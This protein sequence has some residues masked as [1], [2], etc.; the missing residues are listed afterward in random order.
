MQAGLAVMSTAT[1]AWEPIRQVCV[2]TDRVKEAKVERLRRVF[3][4]ITFK[5]G[6][7]VEDFTLRLNIVV[8]QLR[9][10]GD[11]IS[12][13]ELIK[14]MLHIVPQKLKQVAIS[15]ETLLDLDSLSIE[16]AVGHMRAVEQCKKSTPAKESGS[17]LL[18]TEEEWM[19]RMKTKDGSRFSFG[20]RHGGKNDGGNKSKGG[21]TKGERKSQAGHDD[22]CAYCDKKGHWSKECHNKKRDEAAQAHVAQGEEEEQSLLL[23]HDVVL[24]N[25][26]IAIVNAATVAPPSVSIAPR[27][28]VHIEEQQVFTNLGPVEENDRGRWVFNTGAT[29]HMIGSRDIFAKLDSKIYGTVKFGDGS[30]ILTCKDGGHRTLTGVY[31]IPRLRAS[32]ISLGQLD[33][34]GCHININRGVLRIYDEHGQLLAKVPRDGSRLYYLKLHVG[35]PMCLAAHATEAA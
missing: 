2:G 35:R 24:N 25:S 22:L 30:I 34:I 33:E 15:M 18:L 11:D 16:E 32:I 27:H 8:S 3:G 17:H 12:N 19:A 10:L 1:E 13:K 4:D 6:E 9:V 23:A 14:K 31:F 20:T 28:I 21:K 26:P 5:A 7:T 29:N